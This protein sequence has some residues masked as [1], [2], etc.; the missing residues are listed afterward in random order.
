MGEIAAAGPRKTPGNLAG[1]TPGGQ[2]GILIESI[3]HSD[4]RSDVHNGDLDSQAMSPK[5]YS[6][7]A[8]LIRVRVRN[9]LGH[10][11]NTRTS[12]PISSDDDV[13][14]FSRDDDHLFDGFAVDKRLY[15]FGSLCGRLE[16]RLRNIHR[17]I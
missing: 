4:F 2:N 1:V 5:V 13:D 10:L 6:S 8:L 16:V 17:N 3:R 11:R 12:A 14:Q 9:K 15:F 7:L